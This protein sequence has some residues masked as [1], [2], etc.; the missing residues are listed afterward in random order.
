MTNPSKQ[1]LA[2]WWVI[3]AAFQAGIFLIYHFLSGGAARPEPTT[4]ELPIW[5]VG[6]APIAISVFI[7]WLVLPRVQSAQA[8]FPLFVLGI[9]MAEMA[10]FLGLFLFPTHRQELFML[11]ALGIF[12]FVP[13]FARRY[14]TPDDRKL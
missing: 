13:L 4:T 8:A 9:A 1:P 12:Q 2:A 11:S 3:W 6:L 14:F 5:M 10:T 7:R